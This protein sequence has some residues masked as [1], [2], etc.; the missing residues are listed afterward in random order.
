MKLILSFAHLYMLVLSA[1]ASFF[2][3]YA[4]FIPKGKTSLE[5]QN[6]STNTQWT[7][8]RVDPA[9]LAENL[10]LVD[11][12]QSRS[13]QHDRV[14]SNAIQLLESMKSSPSCSKIAATKLLT[15]CQSLSA[16]EHS[17]ES[18]IMTT[19][20]QIKSIYAV[21]LALCELTGA[22]TAIPMACAPLHIAKNKP[23]TAAANFLDIEDST[24]STKLQS[25]LNTLESRPQWWTSY[26]NSRQ[27]AL[28]ICQAARIEV[29]KEEMLNLHQSL[30]ENMANI[31]KGLQYA[32]R[33]ASLEG[34]RH[35][36]F[37]DAVR[38]LR[39]QTVSE[40]QEDQN[41]ARSVFANFVRELEATVGFGISKILSQLKDVES[42]SAALNEVTLAD[43]SYKTRG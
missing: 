19:L 12:I 8:H 27:N 13:M 16:P 4:T 17:R 7:L 31:N 11:F 29:E 33:D 14:F 23:N 43:K 2:D 26:S 1:S 20:D 18:K 9:Q 22:G 15:S 3:S 37:V 28:V 38:D 24:S 10:D 6:E 36:A 42:D 32:L 41:R 25:C 40:L 35:K 30:V 21:R 5:V 39:A 34:A